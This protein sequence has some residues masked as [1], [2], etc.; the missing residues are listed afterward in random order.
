MREAREVVKAMII[1]TVN[2]YAEPC[3][4]IQG[5]DL[6]QRRDYYQKR[7][8]ERFEEFF[9]GKPNHVGLHFFTKVES[10][11]GGVSKFSVRVD[12]NT[13]PGNGRG[14]K[15]LS[16]RKEELLAAHLAS[17]T[18]SLLYCATCHQQTTPG[19]ACVLRYGNGMAILKFSNKL[20]T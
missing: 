20:A 2:V 18:N 3:S 12:I 10:D 17:W 7:T 8:R 19:T 13:A 9:L 15:P 6:R 1:V 5:E 11:F 14:W 16:L 4:H